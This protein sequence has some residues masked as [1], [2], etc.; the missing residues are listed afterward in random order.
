MTEKIIYGVSWPRIS[1]N[2]RSII[3]EDY[4][5][6]RDGVELYTIISVPKG[7]EKCP[8]VSGGTYRKNHRSRQG[9][10]LSK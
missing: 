2:S 3:S 8:A 4:V 10:C 1:E 6:M 7:A 9:Q 5:P